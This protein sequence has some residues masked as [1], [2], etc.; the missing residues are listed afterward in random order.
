MRI[1]MFSG[2]VSSERQCDIAMR[3]E[4]TMRRNVSAVSRPI[5]QTRYHS[6]LKM[7]FDEVV[8][9]HVLIS[10]P[11]YFTGDV[12]CKLGLERCQR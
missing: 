5:R 4:R 6:H 11:P 3:Y 7:N 8:L 9:I 2:F 1:F 12:N 10:E